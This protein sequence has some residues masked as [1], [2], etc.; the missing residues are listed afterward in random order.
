VPRYQRAGLLRAAVAVTALLAAA[1]GQAAVG[2]ALAHRSV[3]EPARPTAVTG[4]AFARA[5]G[6]APAG[7]E[8]PDATLR[9][10]FHSRSDQ[11]P[12]PMLAE[13]QAEP[14][15]RA[16]PVPGADTLLAL[17]ARLDE[18]GVAISVGSRRAPVTLTLYE[19]YRCPDCRDF[20][21]TQ[22]EMLAHL[23]DD[24][25]VLIRRIIES[26]L[27]VRLP[28]DGAHRT[29]NA[30]RAA[31]TAGGFPLYNALLYAYQPPEQRDGFTVGRLLRIAAEVPGLRSST[32]DHAVRTRRYAPWVARSQRA[33]DRF[34]SRV[35]FGT[36][37]MVV[38]GRPVDL[39]A[40]P[41]LARDPTALQDFLRAA[42]RD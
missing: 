32:F 40:R 26:S 20:E 39:G 37:G 17:P 25:T 11:V 6:A 12:V 23:A 16:Q 3:Q 27:D 34:G 29:A 28:G 31:L 7:I 5:H 18:D 2:R 21:Q 4:A 1:G 13:A 38:N 14:R 41:E 8:E 42:A 19:D 10:A 33:Y 24:G 30:A 9:I 15:F 36:P 35:R 22:G